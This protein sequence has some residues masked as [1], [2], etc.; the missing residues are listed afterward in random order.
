M[1]FPSKEVAIVVTDGVQTKDKGPY[2]PLHQ[3]SQSLKDKGVL[4][5]A[6][7]IT[8]DIDVMELIEMAST[9]D[10]VYAFSNSNDVLKK[11]LKTLC[12]PG[13]VYVHCMTPFVDWDR[14]TMG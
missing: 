10:H 4:V 3:A 9:P 1:L 7:G 6:L 8:Y 14:W 5:Y 12:R 2:T 11:I 13:R